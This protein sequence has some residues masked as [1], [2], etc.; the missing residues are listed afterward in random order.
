MVLV[1][2][3]SKKHLLLVFLVGA[4]VFG[5]LW[6]LVFKSYQKDRISTFLHPLTDLSGAGYNSYQATIAIGS[7]QVLGKGIGYGTQSRLKFLPEYQTDFIFAAFAEE[8][9]LVGVL[10]LTIFL[11]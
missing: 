8:W 1:S 2:G 9:G 10:L 7:G 5:G 6:G 3:I 4:M 11:S